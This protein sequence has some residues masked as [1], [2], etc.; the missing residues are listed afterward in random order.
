MENSNSDNELKRVTAHYD[1]FSRVYDFISSKAYYHHARSR[2]IE[3]LK[4]AAGNT[5]LNVPAGTGQNFEYFQSYLHGTGSI[6][7]VDISSGMLRKARHKVDTNKWSNIVLCERNALDIDRGF[8]S[9]HTGG[10]GFDAILCDLG[11]SV[12][13]QWEELIDR[14]VSLLSDEG[15][16][17]IMDCYIDKP[18]LRGKFLKWIGKGELNRPIWQYLETKVVDFEVDSSFNRDGVFV[19]SG[20]K[21]S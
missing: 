2:A 15:R 4:L 12:F 20:S 19:A 7:G 18:S 8:M 11:L 13:P 17:A 1:R 21:P 6:V 10:Q 9:E 14:F 5:V 16:I 3:K